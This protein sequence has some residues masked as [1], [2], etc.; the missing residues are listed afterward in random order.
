MRFTL[1]CC[2]AAA[3]SEPNYVAKPLPPLVLPK[4][5]TELHPIATTAL[6]FTAG[7]NFVYMVRL[8]GFTIGSARLDASETEITSHFATSML[9]KAITSIS[10]DLTTTFE[11]TRPRRGTERLS[12]DGKARQF[13]TEYAGTTSHSIH[14]AIGLVRSW[15]Q[16]GASAGTLQVVVGDQLVRVELTEPSGGKDWLRVEGKLVGLDA[17]A[18]FTCWLDGA[19]VITRIEIRSDG[20]Q[21]TADL[22]R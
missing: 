14:T 21:V 4:Q 7:E 18:S 15:A 2:L 3:C 13:V 11:G 5:T 1:A 17:P 22:V 12:I 19:N 9:A 20:E 8:R 10:H 6:G 16:L